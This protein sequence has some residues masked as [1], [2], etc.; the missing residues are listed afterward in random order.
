MCQQKVAATAF[1]ASYGIQYPVSVLTVAFH[2]DAIGYTLR[3]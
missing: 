2:K 3:N 1:A